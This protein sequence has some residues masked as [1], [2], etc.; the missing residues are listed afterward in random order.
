M[1]SCTIKLYDDTATALEDK[2]FILFPKSQFDEL[3]R[4]YPDVSG[5]FLEI[6]SN[7]ISNK[8]AYLLQLGLSISTKNCRRILR[9]F[10]KATVQLTVSAGDDL[11]VLSGTAIE[12]G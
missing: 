12:N 11:A 8:D 3:L 2:F 6:L 9:M 7:E 1:L 4:F 5:K 10:K